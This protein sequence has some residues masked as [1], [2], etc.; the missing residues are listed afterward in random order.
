MECPFYV[1][2]FSVLYFTK[3]WASH[4]TTLPYKALVCSEEYAQRSVFITE[5]D[6]G[7]VDI[8]AEFSESI[9]KIYVCK[10][11]ICI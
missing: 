4:N 8:L 11:D 6:L 5:F 7:S 2:I 1:V 9:F 3:L 10:I